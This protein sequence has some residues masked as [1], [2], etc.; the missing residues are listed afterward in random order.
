MRTV[1]RQSSDGQ[2]SCN[3]TISANSML[4][5]LDQL[6][7]KSCR[8]S[9]N[10]NYLSIWRSFN[11]FVIRLDVKPDKWED[12]VSL[13]IA[14]LIDNGIQSSTIKSYVSAIKKV[15]TVDGYDWSDKL[16]ELNTLI[17]ACKLVNDRVKTRLPIKG[18]L[19][20]L[21]LFE[22][23]RRWAGKQIY[24][25]TMYKVLFSIAYYGLFRIGEL[26]KSRYAD[27]TIHACNV[28]VGVNKEKI[29]VILFTSKKHGLETY[30]QKVKITS[31]QAGSSTSHLFR[32]FCPFQLMQNYM[33]LCEGYD[34]TDELFFLLRDRTPVTVEM[35][36]AELRILLHKLGLD[37]AL[38]DTHS[39][40]AGRSVDMVHFGC[41]IEEVKRV[42]RWHS[43]AVYHYLKF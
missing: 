3:S 42:G 20:E 6:K 17:K 16:I 40:R 21:L 43:N 8:Q 9:T 23:E 12:R 4:R 27:H 41:S 37:P 24:L 5:I 7:S 14:H 31:S 10:S 26:C 30:P 33:L 22:V 29:L 15:L 36:R 35:V 39:F 19:L 38:Y 13:F 11:K 28:H 2:S 32:N 1:R 34:T 18:N 25:K